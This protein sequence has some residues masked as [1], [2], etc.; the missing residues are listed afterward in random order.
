M[1][2]CVEN[3]LYE[4][5]SRLLS[6][7][8]SCLDSQTLIQKTQT[9]AELQKVKGILAGAQT[10]MS[11]SLEGHKDIEPRVDEPPVEIRK[12][13]HTAEREKCLTNTSRMGHLLRM[14][15]CGPVDPKVI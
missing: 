11:K 5:V 7:S 12:Q 1:M 3:L 9:R 15:L 8:G 2:T 6:V 4:I 10:V 14:G 13:V